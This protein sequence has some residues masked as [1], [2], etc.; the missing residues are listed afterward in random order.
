MHTIAL[1]KTTRKEVRG[2][3]PRRSAR[4]A[5]DRPVA[6]GADRRPRLPDLSQELTWLREDVGEL[7]FS[8]VDIVGYFPGNAPPEVNAIR[9][10]ME[11]RMVNA[12]AAIRSIA[13]ALSAAGTMTH[14]VASPTSEVTP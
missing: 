6:R 12:L 7:Y 10:R 9:D 3:R 5:T 11:R 1:K 14:D 13:E 2:A 4:G 8:A